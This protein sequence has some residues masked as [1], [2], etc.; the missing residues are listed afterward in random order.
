M[1]YLYTTEGEPQGF[2][3]S[4]YIYALDGTPIGKVFAEKAYRLDGTY[5]GAVV[6]NMVVDKP[7]VSRR[8]LRPC[9]IPPKAALPHNVQGRRPIGETWPDCFAGL[10]AEAEGA[11]VEEAGEVG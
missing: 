8:S 2:R 10:L 1:D 6:N 11:R 7:D 9:P 4:D 5:V 3:L